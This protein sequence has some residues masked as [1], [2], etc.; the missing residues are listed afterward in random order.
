[1]TTLCLC[2]WVDTRADRA[3]RLAGDM[4]LAGPAPVPPVEAHPANQVFDASSLPIR[5]L[6]QE[7]SR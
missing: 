5:S 1:M 7:S 2:D 4:T 6:P 3:L